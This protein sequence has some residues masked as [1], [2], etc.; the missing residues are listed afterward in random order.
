VLKPI[1][2]SYGRL[3]EE[4]TVVFLRVRQVCPCELHRSG[5][6]KPEVSWGSRPS[7]SMSSRIV[8]SLN[9]SVCVNR[10]GDG[11]SGASCGRQWIGGFRFVQLADPQLGMFSENESID[12]ELEHCR[13]A[14]QRINALN[15]RP[16]FVIA[17]GDLTHARPNAHQYQVRSYEVRALQNFRA[18][19]ALIRSKLM[20]SR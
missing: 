2:H 15:P 17:C 8:V 6:T 18:Q 20:L 5:P 12:Y 9:R 11:C 19:C 16:V 14:I 4:P 13:L 7:C 1:E 10:C 3:L